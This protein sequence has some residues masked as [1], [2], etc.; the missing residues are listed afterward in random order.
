MATYT[1]IG[2]VKTTIAVLRFLSEQR[3]PIS[4]QEVAKAVDIPH[5]TAMCHL[6]TLEDEGLVR[7]IGG[8]YEIGPGIA[9][10][11]ARYRS[12]LEGKRERI[13]RELKELE[14]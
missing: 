8:C 6:A 5:A 12:L 4:G 10:F 13:E 9:L 1:R 11:H 3:Q 7:A 14:G 2:A